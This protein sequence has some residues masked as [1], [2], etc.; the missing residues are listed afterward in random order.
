MSFELSLPT[1][2]R[3]RLDDYFDNPR[4]IDPVDQDQGAA[5]R[6]QWLQ[7]VAGPSQK[8]ACIRGE[9]LTQCLAIHLTF[10]LE[11]SMH[12]QDTR[13]CVIDD[14]IVLLGPPGKPG[15]LKAVGD[16]AVCPKEA[17]MSDE[18]ANFF[19]VFINKDLT[20]AGTLTLLEPR[21]QSSFGRTCS[22]FDIAEFEAALVPR[23]IFVVSLNLACDRLFMA[24]SDQMPIL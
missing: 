14:R 17:T 10:G 21:S 9:D 15:K 2:C 4:G 22:R 7:R 11:P 3:I 16:V 5:V 13:R 23:A 12:L 6:A 18:D 20:Y 1:V 24:D 8:E 19:A